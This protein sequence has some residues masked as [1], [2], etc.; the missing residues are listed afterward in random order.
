[1]SLI[2]NAI[3][4]QVYPLGALGAPIHGDHGAPAHRLRQLECWLDYVIELGC[5]G[6]LLGPIF[7]SSAHGYDTLDYFRIDPRLGDDADFDHLLDE[8]RSRGLSILLDGVFNHVGAKHRFVAD[9]LSD[10]AGAM[11]KL[12]HHQDGVRV[13]GWEGHGELAT[14]EHRNPAVVDYVAEVMLHWLRRGIDGWRLD[15][16]YSVPRWFWHEVIPRV[17]QEFPNA[18]FIG[19]MIHGDYAA[20]VQE[21]GIDSVTQ[22]ELWK[23]IWSSL[24]S[25]NFW[26]LAWTLTRHEDFCA[27]M[28]PQT[29]VGNHDVD[30]IASLVGDEGAAQALVLLMTT[31]GM[32]SI[33]YGDEQGFRGERS[34][35]EHADDSLRPALPA[36]P[37][38][39][40]SNGAWLYRLHQEL[41]GLRRRNPWLTRGHLR[42]IE[43]Q[44]L[45]ISYEVQG[46]DGQA[47]RV[48]LRL[49]PAPAAMITL[50][51]EVCFDW[52][53]SVARRHAS[54]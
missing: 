9:A 32:P 21:T 11:V 2:D 14:L 33:Y 48:D 40:W 13:A 6:L 29:F 15:A 45:F 12:E 34:K 4:W 53:G 41:I 5:S 27:A 31:P 8:T 43:K 47:L 42:V 7:E 38:E 37:A 49:D 16:A 46:G 35:G 44:N 26:E 54:N 23:A 3:W 25:D 17:R 19:E 39:L 18:L 20:F 36:S 24:K 30:R 51:G 28:V 52:H 22:Y 50:N 1:M 10:P